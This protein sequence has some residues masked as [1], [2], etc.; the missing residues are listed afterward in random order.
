MPSDEMA[1]RWQMM[2]N[3]IERQLEIVRYR[4]IGEGALAS[5]QTIQDLSNLREKLEAL[6]IRHRGTTEH[7]LANA[8]T[9]D[10]D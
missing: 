2:R 6:L 3:D 9:R 10:S 4:A 5:E 8:K 7:S 1:A